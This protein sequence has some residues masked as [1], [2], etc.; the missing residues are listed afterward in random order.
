MFGLD[1]LLYGCQN[2][3]RRIV[4]F[5]SAGKVPVVAEDVSCNDIA[6]TRAG[7]VYFTDLTNRQVWYV[8]PQGKKRVV[9]RGIERPNGV[10]LWGD[11]GKD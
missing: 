2:G 9:S 10:I 5:D 3:K 6:V 11:V 1:G 4:T 8:S 7:S